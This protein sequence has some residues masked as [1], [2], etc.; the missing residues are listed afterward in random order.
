MIKNIDE[1]INHLLYIK[2]EIN[3]VNDF[4]SLYPEACIVSPLRYKFWQDN[5]LLNPNIKYYI[6]PLEIKPYIE[7]YQG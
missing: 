5:N 3:K 2:E 7:N 1:D 4:I 6:A